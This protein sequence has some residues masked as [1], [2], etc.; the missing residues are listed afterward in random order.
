[1][2]SQKAQNVAYFRSVDPGTHVLFM[3]QKE[4]VCS[5]RSIDVGVDAAKCIHR[6]LNGLH[7]ANNALSSPIEVVKMSGLRF[8]EKCLQIKEFNHAPAGV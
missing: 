4:V 1:M 8:P 3:V 7:F 2:L 6:G 5:Q